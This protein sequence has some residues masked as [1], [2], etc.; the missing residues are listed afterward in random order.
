MLG[1]VTKFLGGDLLKGLF[2][3]ISDHFKHKRE[4]KTIRQGAEIALE[5]KK[6]EAQ[7]EI[8]TADIKWDQTMAE[9]SKDS[10]K[11]E[12]ITVLVTFFTFL[13][14]AYIILFAPDKIDDLGKLYQFMKE[15][16]PQDL[17]YF[18]GAVVSAAF[19]MRFMSKRKK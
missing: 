2:G 1:F 10:W 18:N 13:L 15:D 14:P 19:G 8:A 4:I 7:A 17:W 5:T 9:A 12:Y 16:I 6:A 11:D 3:G